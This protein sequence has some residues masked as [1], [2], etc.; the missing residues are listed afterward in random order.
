MAAGVFQISILT[1]M[2]YSRIWQFYLT[3]AAH[4][5][6]STKLNTRSNEMPS[7]IYIW[8][9]MSSVILYIL[10]IHYAGPENIHTP[11]QKGLEFPGGGGFCKDKKCMKYQG[12]Q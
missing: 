6:C 7:Q 2:M 1:V 3:S 11:P 10:F 4:K 9:V 5:L 8:S 12:C